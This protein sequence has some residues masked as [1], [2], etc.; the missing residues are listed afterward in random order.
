M[1]KFC[2]FGASLFFFLQNFVEGRIWVVN[3]VS[4]TVVVNF[5]GPPVELKKIFSDGFGL[6]SSTGVI[7]GRNLNYFHALKSRKCKE[8]LEISKISQTGSK[9]LSSTGGPIKLT[10]TV[11]FWCSFYYTYK[12]SFSF[13]VQFTRSLVKV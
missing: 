11:M 8:N 5:I 3:W 4:I 10:T 9:V 2:K 1:T 13:L 6:L 7:C 12:V